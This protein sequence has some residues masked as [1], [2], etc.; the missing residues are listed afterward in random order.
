MKT[1]IFFTIFLNFKDSELENINDKFFNIHDN[2]LSKI[3]SLE[4]DLAF[5]NSEVRNYFIKN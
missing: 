5:K 2:Y 4:S 3:N 1:L